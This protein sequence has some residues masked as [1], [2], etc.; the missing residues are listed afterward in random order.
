MLVDVL[1]EM[2]TKMTRIYTTLAVA[3]IF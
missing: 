3:I 2:L 1:P